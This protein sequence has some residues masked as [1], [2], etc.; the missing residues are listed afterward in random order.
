M[1]ND[2]EKFLQ[3]AAERL[4]DKMQQQSNQRPPQVPNRP[5]AP[6]PP[7]RQR[8]PLVEARVAQ[9][10]ERGPD[11]LSS[12]DTRPSVANE[13]RP[14]LAQ[15]VS[16]A[17]E[18]MAGHL[19]QVFDHKISNLRQASNALQSNVEKKSEDSAK[20][21]GIGNAKQFIAMLRQPKT[22]QAAFLASEIFRRRF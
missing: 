12:I 4:R 22:L 17:D 19:Q 15:E 3:Q 5:S 2:L 10:R 11:P 7:P 18:R 16:Q 14:H 8:E 9:E 6:P 21:L 13:M 20:V 1:S